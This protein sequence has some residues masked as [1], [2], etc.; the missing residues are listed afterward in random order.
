MIVGAQQPCF[1]PWV[2]YW[3]KLDAVDL[4]VDMGYAQFSKGDYFNRVKVGGVWLTLPMVTKRVSIQDSLFDVDACWNIALTLEHAFARAPYADRLGTII[5]LL[6]LWDNPNLA[7]LNEALRV[8]V[9][10]ILGINTPVVAGVETDGATPTGRLFGM[11]QLTAPKMTEYY[12]GAGGKD[13]MRAF[14]GVP[15]KFQEV[16][17]PYGGNSIVQLIAF[18]QNM[19]QAVRDSARWGT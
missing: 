14:E 6:K 10:D 2:G 7:H 16:V 19:L 8:V 11:L 1:L 3:N 18:E 15:V 17:S 9:S 12:S 4:F 5:D 13:Y